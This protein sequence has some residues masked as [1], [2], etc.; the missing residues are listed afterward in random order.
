MKLEDIKEEYNER[1]K[2][3]ALA[4]AG[5]D[6]DE[7]EK[8]VRLIDAESTEDIEEQAKVIASDVNKKPYI[9]P[10]VDSRSWNPFSE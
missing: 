3:I 7:A 4:E 10:H 9:D 6:I 2:K 5:V 1:L 8:F